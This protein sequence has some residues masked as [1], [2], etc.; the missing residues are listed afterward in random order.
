MVVFPAPERPV[1]YNH[2]TSNQNH[3]HPG[4]AQLTTS[5]VPAFLPNIEITMFCTA[6]Q[7]GFISMRNLRGFTWFLVCSILPAACFKDENIVHTNPDSGFAWK[8]KKIRSS[9]DCVLTSPPAGTQ[10]E[11]RGQPAPETGGPTSPTEPAE[12]PLDNRPL[13]PRDFSKMTLKT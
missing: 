4:K 10:Q 3:Y 12:Q 5:Q 1:H 6:K 13:W 9:G 8:K 2:L 7:V 11:W